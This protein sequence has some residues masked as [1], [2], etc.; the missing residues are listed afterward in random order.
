[1]T[2]NKFGRYLNDAGG[3][4]SKPYDIVI[5]KNVVDFE[6]RLLRNVNRGILK[7]D[8]IIKAQLDEQLNLCLLKIKENGRN[9]KQILDKLKASDVKKKSTTTAATT[10]SRG[11]KKTA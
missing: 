11:S 6:S 8:V 7:N 5:R 10:T 2:I 9:I 4:R 3:A 1:M